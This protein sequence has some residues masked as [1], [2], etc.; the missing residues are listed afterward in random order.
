[1]KNFIKTPD[2]GALL[3]PLWGW[4][5][6]LFYLLFFVFSAAGMSFQTKENMEY[7]LPDFA[8]PVAD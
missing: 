4:V 1:M 6:F 8:H 5:M 3:F 2:A 7:F